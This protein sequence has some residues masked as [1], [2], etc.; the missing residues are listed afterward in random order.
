MNTKKLKSR[1]KRGALER[2]VEMT[3]GDFWYWFAKHY[4]EEEAT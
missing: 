1:Q 2:G 4:N 3:D